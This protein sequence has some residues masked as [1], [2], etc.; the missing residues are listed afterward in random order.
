MFFRE[1]SS[2]CSPI[3]FV[4]ESADFM[5]IRLR[6]GLYKHVRYFVRLKVSLE[7]STEVCLVN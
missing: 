1:V 4:C 7:M 3:L 5:A 2:F 6:D